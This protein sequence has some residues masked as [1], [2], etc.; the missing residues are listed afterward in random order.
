MTLSPV[1]V[2]GITGGIACGKTEVGRLFSKEGFDVLD[3]DVLAHEIMKQG[4]VVYREVVERFG[5]SV[6][7]EDGE[8]NRSVLGQI[9]FNDPSALKRLNKMVHPA[10]KKA[11]EA[12]KAEQKKA[13]RCAAV[14]IPLLFEADWTEGWDAILCVSADEKKVFQ[15]LEKRGLNPNEARKRI[16]A[17]LPLA[18]K[19]AAANFVIKNSGTLDE[20]EVETLH[21]IECIQRMRNPH[22]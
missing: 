1:F 9:V 22:E 8:L 11:A 6:I 17:Q 2:V 21:V 7:G 5:C 13:G 15:R 3:T 18:E 16:A 14:L 12:W 4:T 19:E 20:L 10:V